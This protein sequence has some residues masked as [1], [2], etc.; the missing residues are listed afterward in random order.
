MAN[1]DRRAGRRDGLVEAADFAYDQA[2][3]L[4]GCSD[5]HPEKVAGARK[6]ARLLYA[7]VMTV[8]AITMHVDERVQ[9]RYSELAQASALAGEP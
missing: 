3:R 9:R 5:V 8:D 2:E 6:V 1:I 4:A 7:K